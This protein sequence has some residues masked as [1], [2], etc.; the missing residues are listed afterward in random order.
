LRTRRMPQPI[1]SS[2]LRSRALAALIV[3]AISFLLDRRVLR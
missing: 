3:W 2:P 1:A